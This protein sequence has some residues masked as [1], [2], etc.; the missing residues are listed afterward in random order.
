[1]PSKSRRYKRR[2]KSK[3]PRRKVSFSLTKNKK[4]I[5][6]RMSTASGELVSFSFAVIYSV[7]YEFDDEL[8]HQ[9]GTGGTF[10]IKSVIKNGVI[11]GNKYTFEFKTRASLAR[12][13]K[14][15]RNAFSKV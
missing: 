12:F 9:A 4:N 3:H 1:M 13:L 7:D 11:V 8:F 15:Y 10:E 5:H 14:R 6:S 2:S